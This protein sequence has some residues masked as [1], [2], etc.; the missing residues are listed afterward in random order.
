MDARWGTRAHTHIR[1]A[2]G[3]GSS[4]V[5][6]PRRSWAQWRLLPVAPDSCPVPAGE[7]SLQRPGSAG[8]RGSCTCGGGRKG[9][10]TCADS[11]APPLRAP[12][13]PNCTS[14]LNSL[15]QVPDTHATTGFVMTLCS[16]ASTWGRRRASPLLPLPQEH[17]P[18][19]GGQRKS[20]SQAMQASGTYLSSHRTERARGRTGGAVHQAVLVMAA[21]LAQYHDE[22]HRINVLIS[23]A[24]IRQCAPGE[25]IAADGNACRRA[26]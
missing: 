11:W 1:H 13:C 4:C 21:Q 19:A 16:R 18:H 24:V 26:S 20:V 15:A 23:T 10:G 7:L 8:H 9:G 25:D 17:G 2:D 14:L 3:H 12:A 5:G 22:L 6:A